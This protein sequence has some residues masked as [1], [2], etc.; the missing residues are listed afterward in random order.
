MSGTE[1]SFDVELDRTRT[2][3]DRVLLEMPDNRLE[4]RRVITGEWGFVPR[5]EELQTIAKIAHEPIGQGP[6]RKLSRKTL[7]LRVL[8]DHE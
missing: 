2:E 6:L 1:H 7:S 3:V 4:A 8:V 5:P